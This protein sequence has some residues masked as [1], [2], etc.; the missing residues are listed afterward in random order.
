MAGHYK[1]VLVACPGNAMT[2]GP[3]A[4]H[5][6]VADL[7]RLGQPAA[8]VYFPFD[9]TF[10]TAVPYRKYH[11]PVVPYRDVAGELIVFPEIVTTYALKV[12]HAVAAIWWMSVNNF[13][14][15]RYGHPWRDKIRYFKYTL[16]GLRPWGG[17]QALK[18]LKNF[19]QSD[20]AMKFLAG[21]GIDGVLLS[22]AIPV[23]TTPAYLQEVRGKRAMAVRSNRILFNPH[24]GKKITQQL[25]AAFP[26]WDF[27][28]LAGYN[29]E[30]LAD[31][32]LGSKMYMDFGHHPG[33]D[34]LPREAAIHGCCVITG[35]NGSAGNDI[36][37][38]IPAAYK[39]DTNDAAFVEKFGRQV[40]RLIEDF[41][42]CSAEFDHY[43]DI[44]SR[45]QLE[46]DRQIVHAFGITSET[47]Q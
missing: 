4:I 45:E 2:A 10:D 19:A 41:D 11:A 32:F 33:K 23:Y 29:R 13:T 39:F 25:I 38:P 27:M 17:V 21:N 35:L 14:C 40:Q 3:E 28:P 5:Q 47:R 6:L 8:V 24:K 42:H 1:T 34:R 9:R 18:H 30:Q 20:Y 22:D 15:V 43:R 16:K 7:V 12:R 46:F 31:I 37:V 36:D 26:D 44:I